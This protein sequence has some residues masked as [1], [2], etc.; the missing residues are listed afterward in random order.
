MLLCWQKNEKRRRTDT[1][2]FLFKDRK[3]D[4]MT[5]EGRGRGRERERLG[6]IYE[7]KKRGHKRVSELCSE[8]STKYS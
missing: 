5:S 7:H 3:E 2:T 8:I 1:F 4:K 6:N